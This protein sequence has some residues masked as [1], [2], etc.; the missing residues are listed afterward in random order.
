MLL[1]G[2]I[3]DV[4]DWL[5]EVSGQWWFLLVIFAIAFL[6]SS[7]RSCRARRR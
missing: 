1:A 5:D 3:T 7:S 6:D 4:T 2:I